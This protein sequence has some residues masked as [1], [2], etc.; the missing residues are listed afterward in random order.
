ME[1]AKYYDWN[2]MGKL[3]SG[4]LQAMSDKFDVSKR[5]IERIFK[6]YVDQTQAGVVYPTMEPVTSTLRGVM[7]QLDEELIECI[8]EF[9]ELEGYCMTIRQFTEEFNRVYG[10]DFKKSTMH[11][12]MKKLNVKNEHSYI[13]PTLTVTHKIRRL[14]FM[15]IAYFQKRRWDF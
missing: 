9:N 2:T 5:Q 13:K 1:C 12:Y 14:D 15:N 7:S 10:T 6:E 4:S 8:Y 11:K 3:P